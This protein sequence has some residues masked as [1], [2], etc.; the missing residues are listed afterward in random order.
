YSTLNII[1]LTF[2][3]AAITF[4]LVV[5]HRGVEGVLIGRLAGTAFEA[6]VFYFA[7]R[8][9]LSVKFSAAETRAMVAFGFPLIF[10]QLSFTL[11]MMIDRFFLDATG[12]RGEVGQY[13]LANNIVSVISV[14]VTVPF[15]QVWTVMR[16]SV[17][18]EE[19]AEEY[20][21][22]VLTYIV[23]A[24][25]FL[26]LLVS[27]VG[28]DGIL[29]FA[30]RG[31]WPAATVVPLLALA[32]VLDGASRVLN[33]GIT[34]RKRT[35]FAPLVII[36]ALVFNVGLNFWLIPRYGIMGATISTLLSYVVFCALRFW[37][38][39]LF[40]KVNYEWKRVFTV[41]A[42]GGC[43]L[44]GFYIVDQVRG[45]EPSR[46]ALFLS[47][48]AKITLAGCLPALLYA[49]GFFDEKERRRLAEIREKVVS[50]FL[51]ATGPVIGP[52][53]RSIE[54]S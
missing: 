39:N 23:L 52:D 7:A 41:L 30:R 24:G 50:T 33:V 49:A 27:A 10:S 19:G 16:F 48:A 51:R 17:M 11:F 14:L 18:N 40:F 15:S 6:A 12:K 9:H 2:Q 45:P 42:F 5:L 29:F 13:A 43:L 4:M 26:A 22:R 46:A 8:R 36:G 3:V 35:I 34:L 28:G 53:D 21:S 44:A 25:T 1:S 54:D 31:Y 32:T 20:Y 38:S 37:A 47:A